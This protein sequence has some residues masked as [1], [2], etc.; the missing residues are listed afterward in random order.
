MAGAALP[1]GRRY[2]L[3]VSRF[4]GPSSWGFHRG[5]NCLQR[6][7]TPSFSGFV[8]ACSFLYLCGCLKSK[9]NE[10]NPHT[11]DEI[12]KYI[13]SHIETTEVTVL[14][15][16]NLNMITHAPTVWFTRTSLPTCLVSVHLV[17]QKLNE[18][19]PPLLIS[20]SQRAGFKWKIL[21][22][23]TYI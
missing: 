3:H 13:R 2:V 20:P 6:F 5:T 10:S 7:V 8:N 15:T 19:K 14:P 11:L 12:R 4:S 17:Y 18:T 21:N 16:A 22:M 1:T 9:V 23:Y